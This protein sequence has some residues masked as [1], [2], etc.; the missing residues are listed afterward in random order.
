LIRKKIKGSSTLAEH[1]ALLKETGQWGDYVARIKARDEA[2]Q[3]IWSERKRLEAPLVKDLNAIGCPVK[4]VWELVNTQKPYPDA[5][6][7]LLDHL[8]RPYPERIG[9]YPSM[10]REGIARALGVPEAKFAWEQLVRLYREEKD[11]S[12]RAGLAVAVANIAVAHKELVEQVIPLAK[13]RGLGSSR[14]LLLIALERSPD[15]RA[16]A[17]LMELGTDP[18]LKEEIQVVLKRLR[19]KSERKHRM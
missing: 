3:Q 9:M 4:S 17:T 8:T 18:D 12:A 10:V 7:I 15:P 19:K 1:D 14:L 5:L 13:D 16:R 6:P 2:L 11:E